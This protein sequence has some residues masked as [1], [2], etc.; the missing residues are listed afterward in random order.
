[1]IAHARLLELVDYDPV[2]GLFTSLT[3][4]RNTRG[5][6]QPCGWVDDKGYTRLRVDNEEYFAHV[7]TWFYVKGVWPKDQLDHRNHDVSDYRFDNLREAANAE[8]CRHKKMSRRN[9]SGY[10][11]VTWYARKKRW[12][13]QIGYDWK[14]YGLGYFVDPKDA[15]RA[16]DEAAI[17]FFGEFAKTNKSLGLL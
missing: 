6:G 15:A 10:K 1:M 13:A 17:R 3:E 9:S 7:L 2:A 5:V 16:Y 11:G 4:R 12:M 8:N 14:H